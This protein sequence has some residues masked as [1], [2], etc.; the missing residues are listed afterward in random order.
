[1]SAAIRAAVSNVAAG[2]APAAWIAAGSPPRKLTTTGLSSRPAAARTFAVTDSAGG[3]EI[4]TITARA[5]VCGEP[6]ETGQHHRP[7]DSL[8]EVA[9]AD[10]DRLGHPRP[11]PVD[12]AADL[13][14]PRP[15][16]ADEADRAASDDVREPQRDAVEDRR[17]AI[18]PH[19]QESLAPGDRLELDLVLDRHVVAEQ[20][21]VHPM[22]ERLERLGRGVG[23]GCR[24][25]R[26]IRLRRPLRRPRRSS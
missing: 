20:E 16:R 19:H 1:M 11:Q 7:A 23:P 4:R 22:L 8:V 5:R 21:D 2:I 13:L 17:P 12:Q 24:D 6:L 3:F 26:Q 9:A 18:G 15:G 10:A 14:E 25:Q